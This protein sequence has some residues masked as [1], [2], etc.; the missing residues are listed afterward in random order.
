MPIVLAGLIVILICLIVIKSIEDNSKEKEE[1]LV[2]ADNDQNK[3]EPVDWEKDKAENPDNG[4][5][6]NENTETVTD[7]VVTEEPVEEP[8]PAVDDNVPDQNTDDG[9][10]N[11]FGFVFEDKSDFVDIKNGVNLRAGA[12]VD[13]EKVATLN[14]ETRLERTGKSSEWSRVIY[15]GIECYVR[16]DMIIRSV[17]SIDDGNT[18]KDNTYGFKFTEKDDYV[19]EIVHNGDVDEFV[20]KQPIPVLLKERWK[21]YLRS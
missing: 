1:T 4:N 5:T 19:D 13:T 9:T 2:E 7:P 18:E 11:E 10:G 17:D 8:T 6:D 15:N 12:S 14:A 16:N 21:Q 3:Q 20:M